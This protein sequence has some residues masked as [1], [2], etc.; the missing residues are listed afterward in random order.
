MHP[1]APDWSLINWGFHKKQELLALIGAYPDVA[2][3]KGLIRIL[4]LG[5]SRAELVRSE[6]EKKKVQGKE[7]KTKGKKRSIKKAVPKKKEKKEEKK[8]TKEIYLPACLQLFPQRKVRN[9]PLKPN[10]EGK[11]LP[12]QQ[13]ERY[14]EQYAYV[15]FLCKEVN[16][17]WTPV[18]AKV[19]KTSETLIRVALNEEYRIL[20]HPQPVCVPKGFWKKWKKARTEEERLKLVKEAG[21]VR[22]ENIFVISTIVLDI[23][24]P[25]EEVEPVF[26]ELVKRLGIQGWECGKTKSGNFR[27]F[28]YLKPLRVE[29]SG[30]EKGNKKIKAFYLRPHT[31][32]KNGHTHLENTKEIIAILNAYFRKRGLKADDSFIR[33]NHP[34]WL[35]DGF[36]LL[37]RKSIGETNLYDLYRAVKK[38]QAEE[39]LWETNQKF[40][41]E[42]YQERKEKKKRPKVVIPTFVAEKLVKELDDFTKWKQ[43]VDRLAEK[44]DSYR[45]KHIMLPAVGWAKYLGLSRAEVDDYLREVLWD[46]RNFDEDIEK[47]WKYAEP[48]EFE[49]KGKGKEIDLKELLI[50]FLEKAKNGA[51]RKELLANLFKRQNWL[52]E[53]IEQFARKNE[54]VAVEK[55][56]LT[57]G[58]G[59]KAYVYYLTE[60]GEAF[61]KALKEKVVSEE[62]VVKAVAVGSDINPESEK[63]G[64][65][66]KSIYITPP[67]GRSRGDEC[68]LGLVVVG[69][70]SASAGR[71][72][73]KSFFEVSLSSPFVRKSDGWNE[74]VWCLLRRLSETACFS[75][76]ERE[77]VV[78]ERSEEWEVAFEEWAMNQNEP[79]EDDD[80]NIDDIPF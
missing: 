40:W 16:G 69:L 78:G 70:I 15:I 28:L 73:E 6:R 13:Y 18:D 32:A 79:E 38:L 3:R 62:E 27:A 37:K 19:V 46:K 44:Y 26:L 45:F 61:L 8:R 23:D 77:D 21:L 68:L 49:W 80:V 20:F 7:K 2:Y 12:L 58:K 53:L 48:I 34:V 42:L 5:G 43:A 4:R 9:N 51:L 22:D 33:V 47:A 35:G 50:S 72:D 74:E 36:Y 64:Q 63:K 29:V 25:Y 17:K 71:I 67:F 52:L 31:R 39:E 30:D 57:R 59:R 14:K 54:L 66:K 56:K 76:P 24:S 10:E 55:V 41:K 60:K 11:R 1:S 75:A 65:V